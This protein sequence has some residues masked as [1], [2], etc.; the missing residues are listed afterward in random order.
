V[1]SSPAYEEA[2]ITWTTSKN[3]DALVK[4][5]D[6]TFLGRTAYDAEASTAHSVRINGLLPGQLYYYQVASRD[7]AGNQT[8]DDKGGQFFTFSTLPPLTLPWTDDLESGIAQ[9]TVTTE[10]SSTAQWQM[11]AP[12]NGKEIQAYSPTNAWGVDLFGDYL[13]TGDTKLIGPALQLAGGNVATLS[14]RQSYDFSFRS[15][16]DVYEMGLVQISTD[17]GASWN[18]LARVEGISEGWEKATVDLTAYLGHIVRLGWRYALFSYESAPRPGWLLDDIS[19]TVTNT[20]VGVI[21]VSNNLSQARFTVA[22]PV[23]YTGQ[24]TS[25]LFSGALFGEYVI[26][27]QPVPYY[28]TPAPQTNRLSA[29]EVMVFTGQYTFADTNHNHLP[30]AWEQHYFG[31]VAVLHPLAADSDGDG[32]SDDAEFIAGTNPT[33]ALSRLILA[34]PLR[35]KDG[36]LRF[37]WPAAP[38]HAY[39]VAASTNGTDWAVFS[40]WVRAAGSRVSLSVRPTNSAAWFRVEVRP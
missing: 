12:N 38:G 32:F 22:G 1:T 27:F 40:D 31:D 8:V 7:A 33:N 5:G 14:F 11:G 15:E 21:V 39:R 26:T 28:E 20:A 2:T 19:V 36:S 10:S 17:N 24:G 9:W 30:D 4:F 34:P 23:S 25:A 29:S 3:A 35:V 6:S 13:D 37:V 18:E 16:N